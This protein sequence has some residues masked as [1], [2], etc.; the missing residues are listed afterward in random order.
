MT[1]ADLFSLSL[2]YTPSGYWSYTYDSGFLDASLFTGF[3]ITTNA[4]GWRVYYR[5]YDSESSIKIK[6]TSANWT[7]AGTTSGG[8]DTFSISQSYR[9]LQIA[10][11]FDGITWTSDAKISAATITY[12]NSVEWMYYSV[13]TLDQVSYDEPSAPNIPKIKCR[14]RDAYG[15]AID[16]E[17]RLK[18]ISGDTLD[19]VIIKKSTKE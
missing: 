3:S 18:D 16:N 17:T 2:G 4:S 9:F 7:L 13:Y 10:V 14:G 5:G 19:D 11:I 12:N 6:N 8:T 1:Y 15:K